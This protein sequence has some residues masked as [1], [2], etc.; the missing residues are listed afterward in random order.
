MCITGRW[1]GARGDDAGGMDMNKLSI[2]AEFKAERVLLTHEARPASN[3]AEGCVR[4]DAGER[5]SEQ[6]GGRL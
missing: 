4:S 2:T 1:T 3:A 6:A 5:A